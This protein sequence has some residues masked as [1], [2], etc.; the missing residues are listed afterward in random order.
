MTDALVKQWLDLDQNAATRKQ[1]EDLQAKKDTQQLETL[2]GKRISFGTAG[3]RAR[4]E[5]GFARMNDV[6]VLQASIGLAA[7][8]ARE[9]P[10]A[11]SKGVVIGHDHRHNSEQF[12]KLTALAFVAKGFKVYLFKGLVHTPIVPFSIDALGASCGVMVTASHNPAA[13]NGYKVYWGNGCQIIPP[14][15]TGIAAEIDAIAAKTTK[16]EWDLSKL[17]ELIAGKTIDNRTEMQHKYNENLEKLVHHK[18]DPSGP[19]SSGVVYTAMHGVGYPPSMEAFKLFGIPLEDVFSVRKQQEP[20]P[21]FPT[22]AFPNPEEHGALDL[23]MKLGDAQ[24]ADLIVAN[25]PDADRFAV[26][27]KENGEKWV[28]LTGNQIGILFAAYQWDQYKNSGKKIAMLN[29][30]VSSQMLKF[31]AEKEGFLYEDTLTGFKWIGNRAIDLEKEGYTVP[32]AYEEAIGYM[33]PGVHD[34]DGVSASLV[35]LQLAQAYGGGAKLMAKLNSLYDKYGHFA[36]KN[37]Y[38]IAKTPELTTEAFKHVRSYFK[39]RFQK[40]DYP[41]TIGPFDVTSWRDLTT[42]YDSTTP[43]HKPTLP[44]SASTE[45]ITATLATHDN[46]DEFIRFT[47]RGSGTEPKLKIYIDAKAASTERAKELAQETWDA[48]DEEWWRPEESGLQ[49]VN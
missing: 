30:T 12:A 45:M 36:E 49:R 10:D 23:A 34:K 11:T 33:F 43:D 18:F 31:M 21:D 9:V 37:G 4:M 44:V 13:D 48:L 32:F 15:D 6:T 17:D 25:D 22:V 3:L 7:Y 1:I 41:K 2:L 14:H 42:G 46:P 24:G 5:A 16:F 27:V 39:G 8:V 19:L 38:Y 26:A 35:F 29:S 20:N 28:Q 47:A 40:G